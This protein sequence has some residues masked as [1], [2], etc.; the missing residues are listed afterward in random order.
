MTSGENPI[1]AIAEGGTGA[2]NA[3][4]ALSKLGILGAIVN[5]SVSGKTI[6]FTKRIIQDLALIRRIPI[7]ASSPPCWNRTVMLNLKMV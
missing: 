2:D 7:T 4:S 6:T 3:T 5:A 1:L